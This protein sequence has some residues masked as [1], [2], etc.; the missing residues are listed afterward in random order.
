MKRKLLTIALL[1][2]AMAMNAALKIDRID[3]TDWYVGMKNP[4]L[5][6]MVY[7]KDVSKAEVKTDY[8]GVRIDSIVRLDSP[9]Y[10]LVYLNLSG[11]QPGEMTLNFSGKKVKYQLKRRDKR[12]DEHMGFTNADV[13]YM[14][15]PDRFASG[16]TDN[17]QI[18][19]M[20]PYKNDR[21]QPSLRHGGDLEG[22]R[23]HLDY[24]KQL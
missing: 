22:I 11:A 7:G 8:P 12:G 20:M 15:M 1:T 17:D 23:Q 19:G 13:L 5:Q 6:L 9:N 24:F 3:P 4:S 2:T 16:K 18:K 14:L 10:L 21:S